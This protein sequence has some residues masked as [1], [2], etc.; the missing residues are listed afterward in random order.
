MKETKIIWP[1]HHPLKNALFFHQKEKSNFNEKIRE[2]VKVAL[3]KK[4]LLT[5]S[6][7]YPPS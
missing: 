6:I 5:K 1:P 2:L 4:E 3:V 7:S